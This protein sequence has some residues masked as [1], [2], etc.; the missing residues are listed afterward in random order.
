MLKCSSNREMCICVA[1]HQ[2]TREPILKDFILKNST[3]ISRHYVRALLSPGGWFLS[4]PRPL[5]S[6]QQRLTKRETT[7]GGG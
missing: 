5:P 3:G 2:V 7:A 6:L 4:Q 1:K